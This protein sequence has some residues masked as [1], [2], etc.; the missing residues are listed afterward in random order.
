MLPWLPFLKHFPL[1]KEGSNGHF[2][3]MKMMKS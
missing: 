2:N 1:R 3:L